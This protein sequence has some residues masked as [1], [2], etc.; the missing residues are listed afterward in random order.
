MPIFRERVSGLLQA[1]LTAPFWQLA[2][3]QKHQ[4][5]LDVG[6]GVS[7]LIYDW[8]D[9]NAFFYGQEISTVAKEALNARAPQLNSKLFKGVKLGAA[10]DLQY[11]AKQFDLAIATGFSCY[12]PLDY[13][14]LVLSEVR[15]VLKPGGVFVFDV[16]NPDAELA[17]SWAIL[18]TYSNAEVFL[19]SLKDWREM[20]G[21]E[22]GKI[23]KTQS[24]ELF[25]LYKVGF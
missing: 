19:E 23:L 2:Q 3:P 13:W 9:W 11:E 15:R 4:H 5:C 17:E 12:Y 24:G 6:C 10:H 1:K 14:K 18:E 7:F 22:G 20:I 8:R 25:E 21:S 16:L